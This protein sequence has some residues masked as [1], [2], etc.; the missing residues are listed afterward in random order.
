MIINK[1][2]ALTGSIELSGVKCHIHAMPISGAV[3]DEYFEPMSMA[4]A[5]LHQRGL[6]GLGPKVAYLMLKKEAEKI[7]EWELVKNG[8][9]AEIRR[10]T[11]ILLPGPSGWETNPYQSLINQGKII[12][13]DQAEIDGVLVFFTLSFAV[14][15]K[16]QV[17]AILPA[18][19]GWGFQ[20]EY[21]NFTEYADSLPMS[22]GGD[23]SI[24]PVIT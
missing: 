15:G 20:L 12:G 7:D 3:F 13:E 1:S 8:L 14:M 22:T 11:N 24:Y 5:K 10:L 4:F 18:L 23:N 6:N 17:I 21:L 19:E 16:K 9:M 2:L